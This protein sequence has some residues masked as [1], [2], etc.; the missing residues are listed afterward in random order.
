MP[1][2]SRPDG[3]ESD[4]EDEGPVE[5]DIV[6]GHVILA[7]KRGKFHSWLGPVTEYLLYVD[8]QHMNIPRILI[9]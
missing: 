1:N 5:G 2:N 7:W 8:G 9:V 3:D 4:G 6:M